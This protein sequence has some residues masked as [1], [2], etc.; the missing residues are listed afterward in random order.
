MDLPSRLPGHVLDPAPLGEL[1]VTDQHG[2]H[3]PQSQP[4]PCSGGGGIGGRSAWC[5]HSAQLAGVLEHSPASWAVSGRSSEPTATLR[6][7]GP[8]ESI[9]V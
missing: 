2:R 5:W 4:G 1:S 6:V 3:S 7:S 9:M 8:F